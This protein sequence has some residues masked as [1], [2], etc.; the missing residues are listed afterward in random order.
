MIIKQFYDSIKMQQ[1]KGSSKLEYKYNWNKIN[2]KI[3]KIEY[4]K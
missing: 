3:C 1:N 2:C 4:D